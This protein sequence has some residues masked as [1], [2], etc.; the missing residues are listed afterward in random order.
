MLS[1]TGVVGFELSSAFLFPADRHVFIII[2]YRQVLVEGVLPARIAVHQT[3]WRKGPFMGFVIKQSRNVILTLL[4]FPNKCS[5]FEK[6]A[7]KSA[8]RRPFAFPK[9]A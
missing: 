6:S 4:R 3:A 1:Y 8:C 5:V 7:D 9:A 2:R